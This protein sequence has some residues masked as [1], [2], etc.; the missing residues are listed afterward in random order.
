[1]KKSI[2]RIASGAAGLACLSLPLPGAAQSN[3]TIYGLFDA[4]TRYATNVGAGRESRTTMEDG[5][6][7]GSRLG[8]RVREDLGNG[9]AAALTMESGFDPSSGVS[10]QA[11]P[12]ADFGQ[13]QASPRFWGREVHLGLRSSQGWGV[14]LGRQYTLAH[15]VAARFQPLGNPNSTAHS[16]FSSHHIARQD[17]M[18]R[19]DAKLGGVDLA[20]S[21]T[22][23]EVAGSDANGSWAM[24]A[25]YASG[26]LF[27][28]GYVQQLKN[29]AGTETRKI[30]GLGGNYKVSPMFT[31]FAGAM[32]R[33]DAVSP[34]SNKVW[35]LG[36]NVELRPNVTLSLAHLSDSQTGSTAL[37]GSRKVS[38][39]S[40]SYRFSPRTD[41]YAVVDGNQVDG[42]YAKPA[43]MGAK[44]DQS[45]LTVGLRH[46]F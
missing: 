26:P 36:I 34:Q 24:S 29:L 8:L 9:L 39:A 15:A 7:T 23:G 3:V 18:L 16:I 40:A 10:L 4:A 41:I 32:R 30:L 42:G 20:A 28:G 22:L 27:V 5:I 43:F 44:G 38:Y 2:R 11:T 17:N 33:T 14:L 46:R 19:V 37:K 21:R 31:L 12:T 45:A 1:M 6:F 35:T 25:G 13:T